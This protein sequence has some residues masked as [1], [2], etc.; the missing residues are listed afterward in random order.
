MRK[1]IK[2]FVVLVTLIS[3]LTSCSKV[4][5]GTVGIKFYLYGSDKGVDYE[6]LKPG[7]YYI[8]ANKELY[9]FPTYKQNKTWTNDRREDSPNAEGF[10]FQSNEGLRLTANVGIEYCIESSNVPKVF[11]MYKKGLGEITNKVLRNACRNAFNIASST[12]TA[13]QMYGVGKINF[14]KEVTKLIKTKALEKCITV[15]DVYL[16][17]N[18]GV[19]SE[20]TRA[21]NNKIRAK[22]LAQQK[23]NE[24]KQAQADAKKRVAEAEGKANSILKIAEAQARANRLINAS[25]TPNLIQY[26][27]IKKW[28]GKMPKV[29]GS[30]A[31][32]NLK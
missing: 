22:Q 20:V 5:A 9:I 19:P 32:I 7:R 16:I 12:R 24:L 30:N 31:L 3:V 28:D 8:G 15:T 10:E 14:L 13:E 2:L 21:L 1:S 29:T 26:E 17:G 25:L 18:I 27:K 23:E 4:P 6:V 11:E